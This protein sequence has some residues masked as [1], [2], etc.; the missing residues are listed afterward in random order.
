MTSSGVIGRH[1]VIES[2]SPAGPARTHAWGVVGQDLVTPGQDTLSRALSH[3]PSAFA[4][5]IRATSP[6][7]PTR[8]ITLAHWRLALWAGRGLWFGPRF[9]PGL[10]HLLA[11]A[12]AAGYGTG[13]GPLHEDDEE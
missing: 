10:G 5:G 11:N 3:L 6:K 8:T 1:Q 2:P 12:A 9:L 13:L 4:R 7:V